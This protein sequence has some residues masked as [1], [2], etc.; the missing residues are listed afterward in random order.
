MELKTKLNWLSD[1]TKFIERPPMNFQ[2]GEQ[3]LGSRS[4]KGWLVGWDLSHN[5]VSLF[6]KKYTL[7]KVKISEK[8]K[9]PAMSKIINVHIVM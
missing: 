6:L 5:E 1:W 9:S 4:P 2:W 3:D 7:V 8:V